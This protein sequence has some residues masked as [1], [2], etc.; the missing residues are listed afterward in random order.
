MPSKEGRISEAGLLL[1]TLIELANSPVNWLSTS[2]LIERLII[3]MK[4]SGEDAEILEG[5]NDSR[6]SQIVRNMIS[7]KGAPGNIIHDGYAEYVNGGLKIT[8]IGH[9]YLQMRGY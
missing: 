7:H 3:T 1:P 8:E 2:Q 4:P 6:F 9:K 5:R